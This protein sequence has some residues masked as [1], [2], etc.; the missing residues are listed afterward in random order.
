LTTFEG[1]YHSSGT[2]EEID[3]PLRLVMTWK[4]K[5]RDGTTRVDIELRPE[6]DGAHLHLTHIGFAEAEQASSHEQGW[7]SSLNDLER[8]LAA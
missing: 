1:E 2:Y 6:G 7:A 8:H 3:P 5:T 4:W